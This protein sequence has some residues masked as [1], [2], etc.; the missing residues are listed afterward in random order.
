[1]RLTKKKAIGICKELWTFLAETGNL[2]EDWDGWNWKK[3]GGMK[4]GCPLCEYSKGRH[5]YDECTHCPYY[6]V[7]EHCN[8]LGNP[9]F[10]WAISRTNLLRKKYAKEFLAQL[11]QL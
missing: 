8:T 1:M 6:Q 2:K 3:Y 7:F 9:Y 4:A 10:S 5:D 11:E